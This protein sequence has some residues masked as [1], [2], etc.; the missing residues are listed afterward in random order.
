ML[1]VDERGGRFRLRAHPTHRKRG[2]FESSW[3]RWQTLTELT[4]VWP[5]VE[6]YLERMRNRVDAK[7]L[8]AEAG[9]TR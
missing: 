3:S 8:N 6:E 7:W 2:H 5:G 9:C 1:D 4:A